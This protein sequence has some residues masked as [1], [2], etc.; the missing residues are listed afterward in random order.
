M[1][2]QKQIK[3]FRVFKSEFESWLTTSSFVTMGKSFNSFQPLSQKWHVDKSPPL[4]V[5]FCQ[6]DQI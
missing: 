4:T 1:K 6:E 2:E 3:Y 5:L